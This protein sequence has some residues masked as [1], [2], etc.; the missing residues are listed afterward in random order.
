LYAFVANIEPHLLNQRLGLREHPIEF[1]LKPRSRFGLATLQELPR[2]ASGGLS[3]KR[4][5]K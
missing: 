5:R 3:T 4:G 2:I 1:A